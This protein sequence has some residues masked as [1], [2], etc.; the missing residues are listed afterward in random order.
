MA[1]VNQPRTVP[2]PHTLLCGARADQ[3]GCCAWAGA[4][5]AQLLTL[6]RS[7]PK[8]LAQGQHLLLPAPTA[9]SGDRMQ[10]DVWREQCH[11]HVGAWASLGCSS[12]GH[13][14]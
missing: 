8:C 5:H 9:L 11:R 6:A 4:L 2:A 7:Q 1:K 12:M 3:P 14:P 10:G 13:G